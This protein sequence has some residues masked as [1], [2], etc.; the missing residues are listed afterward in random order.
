MCQL[1]HPLLKASGAGSI[2]FISSVC[3]V[4]G[5]EVGTPYA[6]SKDKE[7]LESVIA[8]TPMRRIGEPVEV[9]ALVAF[10][11]MPAASY[12]TGQA[13]FVDG[14]FTVNCWYP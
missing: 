9:A 12:I 10:L 14:G 2:V 1:S 8:Q 13:I 6:A 3:G 7:I 5:V 11:C 4:V